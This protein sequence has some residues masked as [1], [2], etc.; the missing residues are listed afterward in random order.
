VAIRLRTVRDLEEYM[1]ATAPIIHYFGDERDPERSERFSRQLPF[2]RMHAAFADGEIIAGAGVIPFELT[3]PG[4]PVACAGVTVVGVLPTHRRRGLLTRLMRAQLEDIRGRGEPLAALWASEETIYGR[5]GYGLA[6]LD[7]MMRATRVHAEL[8]PELPHAGAV[9]LVGHDEAL[10]EF[11]RIYE[12][13]R[14]KTV[15]FLSRSRARWDGRL[16]DDPARRRGGGVLNHALLELEGRAAG[17]ALYRIR[18]GFEDAT[19]TSQVEVI[20]A[21]GDSP[22]ATRELWRF[23]LGIDWI[24]EIH[25]DALAVDHPLLLLV[26]RPNKLNWKVFDGLWLRLVDVPAALS[27][28]G[29]AADGRVTLEVRADPVFPDNEGTW[30]VDGGDARRTTRRPDVRL[31]VQSLAAAY[32]GGFSFLDLARAGRIEEVARGGLAR[33]DTLFRVGAKPWCPEIF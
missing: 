10:R 28:R 15:G 26:Q 25:C 12:R 27:A 4:G 14:R 8:R 16:L 9:R 23:L 24:Q 20:E 32:L 22:T 18:P 19:N 13:L 2:D 1:S 3:V 5:Y 7:A 33:A 11:P 30:T 29:Y 21:F 6:S 17:Y 31:D